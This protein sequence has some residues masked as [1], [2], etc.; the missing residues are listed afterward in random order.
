MP[1][2]SASIIFQLLGT[3]GLLWERLQKEGESGRRKSMS[4]RLCD[5]WHLSAAELGICC[6]FSG[7][8]SVKRLSSSQV[9]SWIK[10][11]IFVAVGQSDNDGRH[12]VPYVAW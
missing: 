2:I 11:A 12:R 3:V 10:F 4:T 5:C 6:I 7:T 8:V 1:Y 9:S